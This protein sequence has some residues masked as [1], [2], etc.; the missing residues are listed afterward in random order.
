MCERGLGITPAHLLFVAEDRD[1]WRLP[2]GLAS[3]SR[4]F[5][6]E[7]ESK[8]YACESRSWN[9]TSPAQWRM[10]G[11][12]GFRGSKP[13]HWRLKKLKTSL[14]E[15]IRFFSYRDCRNCYQLVSCFSMLSDFLMLHNFEKL[16]L[17]C[18]NTGSQTFLVRCLTL[19]IA[20]KVKAFFFETNRLFFVRSL[21]KLL[22]CFFFCSVQLSNLI[23]KN[24]YY[25]TMQL[26]RHSNF[27]NVFC[28]NCSFVIDAAVRQ[29]VSG[30][31]LKYEISAV[32]M[33]AH[34]IFL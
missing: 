25:D 10:H 3:G 7:S 13:P 23:S 24:F 20:E 29:L 5:S 21:P 19:T 32:T 34:K 26:Y 15:T 6:W 12:G 31:S 28:L 8:N 18:N 33:A 2:P 17:W 16:S 11:G 4:G 1:A 22:S 14:F 9:Y 27:S 30:S